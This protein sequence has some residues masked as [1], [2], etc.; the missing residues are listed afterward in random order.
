MDFLFIFF[1]GLTTGGLSC[2][3]VQ[4]GL[5]TGVISN[6]KKQELENDPNSKNKT[7]QLKEIDSLDWM[8]VLLFLVAKLISHTILGFML[9]L[10]GSFI[11]LSL[12]AKLFF[13]ALTALF[14][15]ASAM[16]LMNVHPIFRYLSFQPPKWVRKM[17]K[18]KSKNSSLF[19]PFVLGLM[20]IFIPCGVTQA[21]EVL[22]INSGNPF[23]GAATMF[24]FVLGTMP[25]FAILGIATAKLSEVWN[26]VFS[27][28]AGYAL[29]FMA[30][31]T[32]NGV[33]VVIDSPL[34]IQRITQP[35]SHFFSADRFEKNNINTTAIKNGV[36][37]VN[38]QVVNQG[39]SP[40]YTRVKKGIP[41]EFTL[42]S[43]N[44]YS[45]ALSFVFREFGIR[46]SLRSTD[47]QTFTFTPDKVG[48]YT[49]TCSMGMYS[50]ILEVVE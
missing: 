10:A 40:S 22:A 31:Y 37:M 18:G 44:T 26:S 11:T 36:Q 42:T 32:I 20:T 27:K 1:T 50:G 23:I 16:N 15:F 35:I 45:C 25:L 4:G 6:Q 29:I 49:F 14:M 3:A 12:D 7:H 5:L 39:Y 41:V 30:L 9:G 33:L 47:K 24:T 21:M 28:V 34:T 8:P 19:A 2:L 38:I 48:R 13:Q 46:T 43:N 17:I